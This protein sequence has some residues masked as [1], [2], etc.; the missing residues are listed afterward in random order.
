MG[1]QIAGRVFTPGMPR[2]TVS[3]ISRIAIETTLRQMDAA[4]RGDPFSALRRN[5]ESVTPE[6]WR[7]TPETW[8]AEEFGTQPELSICDI[9]V[10]VGA[11]K[12]MYANRAF[13]DETMQWGDVLLPPSFE[14]PAVLDW[15]EGGYRQLRDGLAALRGD[16]E[17]QAKRF[18]P[19]GL[20][21]KRAQLVSIM[22]SHD[23]YHAGEINRQRALVRG[24]RGWKRPAG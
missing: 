10:H 19:W 8:S 15:L 13:G 9:V 22:I 7:I 23:L 2:C 4:Y 11:A 17:L 14:M 12:Y 18:A 6:E 24:A 21:L 3:V 16:E 5:V 1:A 20:Q